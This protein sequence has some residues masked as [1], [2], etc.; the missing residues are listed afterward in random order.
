MGLIIRPAPI[1][2]FSLVKMSFW[3]AMAT[4]LANMVIR[5]GSVSLQISFLSMMF[6]FRIPMHLTQSWRRCRVG[7]IFLVFF[8]GPRFFSI[9]LTVREQRLPLLKHP[10]G[11]LFSGRDP[12]V[13]GSFSPSDIVISSI[14][15]PL[16][17]DT[18]ES[19]PLILSS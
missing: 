8:F 3:L 14:S 1:W 17:L 4:L 13:P 10:A 9:Y 16:M 12:G 7:L 5:C 2:C 15:S 11:D 19:E 18:H 6:A